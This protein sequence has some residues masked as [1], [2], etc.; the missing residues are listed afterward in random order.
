MTYQLPYTITPAILNRFAEISELIGRYSLLAEQN[1]TPRLRR[2]KRIR[3]IQASLSIENNT[4]TLEQVTA[5]I[6]VKRVLGLPREIREV[7]N[8]FADFEA[9]E[10]WQP[11][12]ESDLLTWLKRSKEPP[13]VASCLFHYERWSSFIHLPMVTVV[14]GG[15]GKPLF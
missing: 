11:S 4:L 8:A 10:H 15:Y 1:Q 14:W 5:V 6:D 13:L 7:R 12:S 2:E 9:M 3:I